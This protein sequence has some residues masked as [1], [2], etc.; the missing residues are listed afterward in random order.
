MNVESRYHHL[1]ILCKYILLPP[2]KS[3]FLPVRQ[4]II[5]LLVQAMGAG[6]ASGSI[7]SGSLS[8]AHLVRVTQL[9]FQNF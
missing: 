3:G 7:S 9:F 4:D 2:D 5:A 6:I 1:R 8:Q